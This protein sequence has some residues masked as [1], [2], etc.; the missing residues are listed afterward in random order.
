MATP[1][2][3]EPLRRRKKFL[4][5]AFRVPGTRFRFGWDAIIGLIPWAGDLVTA[6]MAC[7]IL[8][9]AHRVRVPRVIQLRMLMNVALDL[10]VGTVP[11]LGD[12][13]DFFWKANT[14]NFA[15]LERHATEPVRASAGDWVFVTSVLAAVVVLAAIPFLVVYWIVGAVPPPQF[16][17]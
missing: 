17:W 14:R 9:H 5:E 15:L 10:L 13:A 12:V 11:F 8:V 2:D 3:L 1:P 7:M 4:D 6:V 16:K